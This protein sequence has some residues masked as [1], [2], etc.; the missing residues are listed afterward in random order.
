MTSLGV[1][2]RI[3]V[4]KAY[5]KVALRKILF[6]ACFNLYSQ[7]TN[8]RTLKQDGEENPWAF[9]FNNIRPVQDRHRRPVRTNINVVSILNSERRY[10]IIM[11]YD[12]W[13]HFQ[14][15]KRS[16]PTCH[17]PIIIKPDTN[18]FTSS[19]ISAPLEI[20]TQWKGITCMQLT[21]P[22]MPPSRT[23]YDQLA[24]FRDVRFVRLFM[25]FPAT[26]PRPNGSY[27]GR[28]CLPSS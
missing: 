19:P 7:I 23:M 25:H 2:W 16:R 3:P 20:K 14:A 17:I 11:L 12:R 8:L 13:K 4:R 5:L 22:K 15:P 10:G 28:F 1:P 6:T 21:S 26:K 27:I 18:V 9:M 24:P